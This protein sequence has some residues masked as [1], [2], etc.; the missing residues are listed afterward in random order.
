MIPWWFC[1]IYTERAENVTPSC[2]FPTSLCSLQENQ[3]RLL[4]NPW[5]APTCLRRAVSITHIFCEQKGTGRE[6]AV[7]IPFLNG[8]QTLM[9]HSFFTCKRKMIPSTSQGWHD[10]IKHRHTWNR[11]HHLS[12]SCPFPSGASVSSLNKLQERVEKRDSDNRWP[13][14]NPLHY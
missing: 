8:I 5:Q 4:L 3:T 2:A 6:I 13:N 9:N 12:R 10:S 14:F 11:V 1:R 7:G